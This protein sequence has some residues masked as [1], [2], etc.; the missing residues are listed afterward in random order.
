M[1]AKPQ[2]YSQFTVTSGCLCY[3][4]LHNIWYGASSLIQE[5]PTAI[6]R[7]T[8]GTVISQILEF[9]VRAM[10]GTWNAFQLVEKPGAGELYALSVLKISGRPCLASAS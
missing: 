2:V 3:G 8:G 9:N 6:D 10:N 4:A 1:T 7:R 5:F